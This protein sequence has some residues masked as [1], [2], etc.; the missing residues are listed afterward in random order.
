MEIFLRSYGNSNT[1][2][3]TA[4][5]FSETIVNRVPGYR[6]RGLGSIPDATRFSE[7]QWVWNGVHSAS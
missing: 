6:S 2:V 4:I 7:K 5:F 1:L 3:E